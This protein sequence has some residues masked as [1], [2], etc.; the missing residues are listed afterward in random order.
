[1]P[2]ITGPLV[3]CFSRY[4]GLCALPSSCATALCVVVVV[5]LLVYLEGF[6][7]R[8]FMVFTAQ[9]AVWHTQQIHSLISWIFLQLLE[10]GARAI[11]TS[12]CIITPHTHRGTTLDSAQC[13][14]L[15]II[16]EVQPSLNTMCTNTHLNANIRRSMSTQYCNKATRSSPVSTED[17]SAG[18]KA[19]ALHIFLF[20]SLIYASA[21][22][23]C[24]AHE[25]RYS[26][27]G[28]SKPQEGE[29]VVLFLSR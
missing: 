19:L 6:S 24:S 15:L 28:Q 7:P 14:A 3:L 21:S 26:N 1:M 9:T 22:A 29:F 16:C 12:C 8:I 27:T 11:N 23:L 4:A 10:F 17:T 25:H 5:V 18:L 20:L 13:Q 2:I